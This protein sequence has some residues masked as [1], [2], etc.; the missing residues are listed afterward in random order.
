MKPGRPKQ[1]PIDQIRIERDLQCR[2]ELNT[3]TISEYAAAI[4]AGDRLPPVTVFNDNGV[5]WL[6]AGFHRVAA[7]RRA[8]K[9]DVAAQVVDGTRADAAWFGLGDNRVNGLRMSNADKERAV[10]IALQLRP[11]DSDRL[12]ASHI[13]VSEHTV[14][15]Y[16]PKSESGA[17]VAHLERRTGA[18]GKQ[19]PSQR[20]P[21]AR[22]PADDPPPSIE[23]DGPP[24]MSDNPP[25][26]IEQDGP[27]PTTEPVDREGRV[28]PT[29][30]IAAAFDRDGIF[31]DLMTAVSRIKTSI[32]A[33]IDSGDPLFLGINR[34]QFEC[35]CNN[36]R[37]TIDH[38]RPYAV[39]PYCSG[40]GKRGRNKCDACLGRGFVNKVTWNMAPAELRAPA[41]AAS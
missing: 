22:S 29:P 10:K 11:G 26:A 35:D 19:Y 27:P 4:E 13:G 39:C 41:G 20:K 18:D 14:A 5:L 16:R 23:D 3:E 2:C 17:Q 6:A 7:H 9:A 15:K 12:I 37:N 21:A 32:L 34:S 36:V 28:I 30:E 25:P 31:T 40:G 8:G 1:I 38:A 24:A 33:G